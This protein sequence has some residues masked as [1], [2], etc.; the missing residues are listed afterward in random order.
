MIEKM[1]QGRYEGVVLHHVR[2]GFS[3]TI[4]DVGGFRLRKVVELVRVIGRIVAGRLVHGACV[5]YYPPAGPS[6]LAM[7]RDMVILGATRWMF[8]RTIFHF[9]AGGIGGMYE[10]LPPPLRLLYRWAYWRPDAAIRTSELAP[11]DGAAL[12][13]R[14]SFVVYNGV[15]DG[16]AHY[17][18]GDG[19]AVME[20]DVP[21]I[22]FVGM[23]RESKGVLVLLEA[24]SLLAR[25]GVRFEAALMGQFE[26]EAFRKEVEAFVAQND[27]G[28]RVRFLGV[29]TGEAKHEA[30]ASSDLLCF[31]T[32][33]EAETFGLVL[34]EAFSYRLPVVAT[35]WRG[36][37]SIVDD[38]CGFLVPI[39]DAAAVADRLE[40][41]IRDPELRS[42]M[43]DRGREKYLR[44]F[45]IEAHRKQLE[46]VFQSVRP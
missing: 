26:S 11:D 38:E 35:R 33:Y 43:G 40:Q 29:L 32:H 24:C 21:R 20:R 45:T 9:H 34:V 6:R 42:R 3:E 1:L 22:L 36:I 18:G 41:L 5:L 46:Q 30:F 13:A 16:Y 23:L 12:Q 37:P 4:E 8:D 14:R 28:S 39:R 7:L 27:L 15:E 19:Q 2:M 25:R 17:G 10:S 31:P 44:R